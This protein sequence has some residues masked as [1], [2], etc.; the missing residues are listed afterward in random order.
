MRLMLVIG[1]KVM[2]EIWLETGL[3]T[4]SS[5]LAGKV[6]SCLLRIRLTPRK[7]GMIPPSRILNLGVGFV[8]F[9]SESYIHVIR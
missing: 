8:V 7:V 1:L 3:M 5:E 6:L 4:L 2:L 9:S